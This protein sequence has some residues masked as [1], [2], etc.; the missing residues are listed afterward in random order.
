MCSVPFFLLLGEH[1]LSF[2]ACTGNEAIVRLL[3]ENGA[4][5]RAQ[6]SHGEN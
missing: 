6:D 2:A 1:I 4:S 3:I 5:V